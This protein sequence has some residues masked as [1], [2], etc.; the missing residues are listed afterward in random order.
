MRLKSA[1]SALVVLAMLLMHGMAHG[2]KDELSHGPATN[3]TGRNA[4]MTGYWTSTQSDCTTIVG[5][6]TCHHNDYCHWN[7]CSSDGKTCTG[8]EVEVEY[9]SDGC[10]WMFDDKD[11]CC[12]ALDLCNCG[13]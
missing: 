6:T 2:Q 11:R 10:W 9:T 13:E 12:D 1:H 8:N 5:C 3:A 4:A 7:A